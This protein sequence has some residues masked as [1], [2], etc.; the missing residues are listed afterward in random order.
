MLSRAAL[1]RVAVVM[2][3]AVWMMSCTATL[4]FEECEADSDC[5]A[6]AVPGE[7]LSCSS[8]GYCVAQNE[9]SVDAD[10][11]SL[12]PR[13][14][15]SP[16]G[17]CVIP[18]GTNN[19]NGTN[20]STVNS[21]T[22]CTNSQCAAEQGDNYICS[23]SCECVNAI[24][25]DCFT[26]NG[27]IEQDDIVL[28][29]SI[30]PTQGDNA[31]IGIPIEQSI[32]MAVS[33]INQAGGLGD[34]RRLVH[35]GCNS[36]GDA[37]TGTRAATHLVET[38]GAPAIVGPA[39]STVY[40]ETSDRVSSPGGTAIVSPSATSPAITNLEDNGLSWRTIPSDL[41]QGNAMVAHL[42][43]ISTTQTGPDSTFKVVA[44]GKDDAYG[45]GL[46]GVLA[47][48][49]AA[50]LGVDNFVARAYPDPSGN[51]AAD[52]ATPTNEAFQA[53]GSGDAGADVVVLCGTSEVVTLVELYEQLCADNGVRPPL[54]LVSDGGKLT[55]LITYA[56]VTNP[57]ARD[58]I[59][60]V[61]ADSENGDI[62]TSFASRYQIRYG[63]SPERSPYTANAYDATYLLGLSA[64]SVPNGTEITGAALAEGFAKLLSGPTITP[65]TTDIG[66]ARN[67]LRSGNTIDFEGVSGPLQF[68]LETGDVQADVLRW[69]INERS[70]G[71]FEFLDIAVY[72]IDDAGNGTWS[73]L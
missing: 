60:G 15:C 25:S 41:F 43:N 31:S 39:F 57:A 38:L 59:Q 11:A 10:C 50:P 37:T 67:T 54:Y 56:T 52:I 46:L 47:D 7:S 22:C 3:L 26:I 20:N 53:I 19:T 13:T 18:D 69:R 35:V 1:F 64:M 12:T 55:E 42:N 44:L 65:S 66:T 30:L 2:T 61:I 14:Q 62:F 23:P 16:T 71:N 72:T 21:G 5:A 9:C 4:D 28:I 6:L 58:R 48:G 49:L 68:D 40:I 32:E 36:S 27:P 33:E 17:T 29:G 34:G 24:S 45:N 8:E 73:D 63:V 70:P 51:P